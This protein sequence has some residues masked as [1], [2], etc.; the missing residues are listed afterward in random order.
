[1]MEKPIVYLSN[2]TKTLTTL[3]RDNLFFRG[4][5]PFAKKFIFLPNGT[6]KNSLLASFVSDGKC[7]VAFGL[8]FLE[9][10]K[11]VSRLFQWTAGKTL[12]FPPQDLLTLHLEALLEKPYF[13]GALAKEF[14]KYGKYGG[15]FFKTWNEGWQKEIWDQVTAKWNYPY[16]LLKT[17]LKKPAQTAEI[18]LYNFP[19]LPKLYH[20]FFAKLSKYF[21]IHYYQF[22]PCKEF[23]SDTLSE[24]E[25]VHL[26][27]KDPQ[28]SFYL[29][30][31]H[32]LLKNL[33]RLGRETFRVFEEEDFV[34]DEHYQEVEPRHA[35]SELQNGILHFKK[36]GVK[37]DG[38][39]LLIPAPSKLREVEILYAKLLD[40]S[41]P[42]SEIQVFAP[43]IS[44]YAPLIE[45][46][47]GSEES[48]FDFTIRDLPHEPFLQ[49]FLDLLTLND[50]R[51]D[52]PSIFKLFESPY[53]TALS[54]KEVKEF[55]RWIDKS[56]VKWGVDPSHRKR[57]LPD[58]L[59][60]TKHGTWEEAFDHLL[61][62]L[63]F[64]PDKATDWDLPYLDFSDSILLGKCIHLI[65]SLRRDLDQIYGATLTSSKWCDSLLNLLT[66]YL[67][68]SEEELAPLQEKLLLLK[69]LDGSYSFPSIKRYLEATLKQKRGAR[70]SKQLE[71]ITFRSLKPGTIFTS[72]TI[73]LLGMAEGAFPRPHVPS[74][75]NVLDCKADYVPTSIDEDRFLFL[76]TLCSA[77]ENLLITYQS[78]SEEDGKEQ[79]PSLLVQELDPAVEKHPPFPFHYEYF[80]E[81]KVYSKKH[82]ETAKA[83]YAP[84]KKAPF[85]PEFLKKAPLPSP[86]PIEK[87]TVET[88][89]RFAKN[90]LRFY[91]NEVLNLYLHYDDPTDPEFFL[92][93]LQK[94]RLL[95][96]ESSLEEAEVR[97]H[98]PLG[99]FKD[100]AKKHLQLKEEE[101]ETFVDLIKRYPEYLFEF[102]EKGLDDY[103]EYF[104]IALQTPSPFHPL[105]AGSF[106]LKDEKTLA[107]RIKNYS[108]NDPYMKALFKGGDPSVI[109]E[110]WAP[111]LR[112][113]F[114]PFLELIDAT[115]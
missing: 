97:G 51:F 95:S 85:I 46:V 20:L 106:L 30:E 111:Y 25:K 74:S 28:L 69:E 113:I 89:T 16:E 114:H 1:M 31:G 21:P 104:S 102:P 105:L 70:P 88:L 48:P 24:Y 72:H 33:G 23:W 103:I 61:K 83:F 58:L 35:L 32:P 6:L 92:S 34:L 18:H 14:I 76:E 7:D 2:S 91:C 38:S 100:I 66:T 84:K 27:E 71:A 19:F 53:F 5:D 50:S 98:L 43:D 90:P 47:F 80:K 4:K 57:L 67:Q 68:P 3:L 107:N 41:C 54:E 45:L 26:I 78:C 108:T 37:K 63:V 86:Q 110:T 8:D 55:K 39:M 81:E 42:P 73:A 59:D 64:I 56:G 99:R 77:Q 79:P 22:S 93:P 60:N 109:F 44:L 17:P 15:S 9:L 82:F 87:P 112:K 75:L 36:E 94:H 101:G 49:T 65:R 52:P 115:V 40:L 11:G 10:G 29:D 62:N 12:L 96:N 13:A